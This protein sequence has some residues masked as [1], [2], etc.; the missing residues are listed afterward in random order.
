M[1][2]KGGGASEQI[3]AR[4][5]YYSL[6]SRILYGYKHFNRWTA[7]LLML[8]TLLV[9]PF[10]RLAFAVFRGSPDQLAQTLKAYFLLWRA[11]P[12]KLAV[13][14]GETAG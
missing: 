9:E 5:L 1:Y 2:H 8:G 6:S 7:T 3:K 14:P 13:T 4:S 12:R 10:S 11:L